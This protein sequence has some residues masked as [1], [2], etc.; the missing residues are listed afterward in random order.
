MTIDYEQL[1]S[2]VKEAMFTGGGINEP[3]APKGVPHRM[4]AGDSASKQQDMGDPKANKLYAQAVKAREA[5]E[6]LVE[7]LDEPIYDGAY[8][9][10]FRASS[11]MRKALNSIEGAGAVPMPDEQVVAPPANRQRWG[12]YVPYQGAID[13]GAGV[14]VMGL[15]EQEPQ[16]PQVGTRAKKVAALATAGGGTQ[17]AQDIEQQLA[18]IL[19]GSGVTPLKLRDALISLLTDLGLK[20]SKQVALLIAKGLDAKLKGQ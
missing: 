11:S 5:V 10:A 6:E 7:A 3:S 16:E 18:S 20:N 2:L 8:E 14:G 15:E 4:P 9:H 1:R 17:T 19:T 13:Y 12:G